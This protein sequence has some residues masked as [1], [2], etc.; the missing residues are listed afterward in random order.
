MRQPGRGLHEEVDEIVWK[1]SP[2]ERHGRTR[3]HGPLAANRRPGGQPVLDALPERY[4]HCAEHSSYQ[5]IW[6]LAVKPHRTP[7]RS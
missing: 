5:A 6:V 1:V 2:A 3:D 7:E 4:T